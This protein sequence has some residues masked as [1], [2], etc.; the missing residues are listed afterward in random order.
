[1]SKKRINRNVLS[2][3]GKICDDFDRLYIG[4]NGLR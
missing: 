4:D 2:Q 1:M 3:I